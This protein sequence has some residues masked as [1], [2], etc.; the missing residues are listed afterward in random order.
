LAQAS[1]RRLPFGHLC[2]TLFCAM[3]TIEGRVLVFD[4]PERPIAGT[5]VAAAEVDTAWVDLNLGGDALGDSCD[6]APDKKPSPNRIGRESEKDLG[7]VCEAAEAREA[8]REAK[9]KEAKEIA[10]ARLVSYVSL[11]AS[12]VASVLGIGIGVSEAT[13]SLVGFGME[14]F[15]DGISSALV[16]WRFKKGKSREHQ[17]EEAAEHFEQQR[18]ARRERNSGLGIGATFLF[19]ALLLY[20]SAAYKLLAWDANTEEHRAEESAGAN[21]TVLLSMPASVVFGGLAFWKLRL[22]KALGSQVLYKDGLCSV[23]GAVLGLICTVAGIIEEA[24]DSAESMAAVDAIASAVIASILAFE[25]A[26]TLR[27]NWGS[28][29]A[30][31]HQQ[32][33]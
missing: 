18:N 1:E 11:V 25:G 28:A 30:E 7:G 23:L 22:A 12:A 31:E 4:S 15:L 17:D 13:L 3:A 2:R 24:S 10:A 6:A 26:R 27:H 32:M 9:A 8:Q 14:A 16:L 5:E 21:Y 29:W 33:A 19:S 20:S